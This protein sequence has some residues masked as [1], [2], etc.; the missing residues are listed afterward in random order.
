MDVAVR[1]PALGPVLVI[2]GG[3]DVGL[4]PHLAQLDEHA[5]GSA[6]VE[7]EVVDE[8]YL[9]DRTA[10]VLVPHSAESTQASPHPGCIIR[11]P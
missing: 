9:R 5:L 4:G 7:Q 11:S 6:D 8:G 3:E 10:L 2:D 1:E